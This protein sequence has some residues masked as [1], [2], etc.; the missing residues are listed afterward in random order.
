MPLGQRREQDRENVPR[1]AVH[2]AFTI[3]HSCLRLC[4]GD[5]KHVGSAIGDPRDTKRSCIVLYDSQLTVGATRRS[6]HHQT[7]SSARPSS[8]PACEELLGF[9]KQ[10]H[11][12][13]YYDRI[14]RPICTLCLP[15]P[16]PDLGPPFSLRSFRFPYRKVRS[17]EEVEACKK[18]PAAS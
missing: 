12:R 5:P 9:A 1:S 16:T 15:I 7:K 3:Y 17:I 14:I 8:V 6:V 13:G 4:S 11:T 2:A 10:L 18:R